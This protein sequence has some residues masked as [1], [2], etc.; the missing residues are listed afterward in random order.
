MTKNRIFGLIGLIWGGGMILGKILG[1]SPG[2]GGGAYGAGQ[3]AGL[4]FGGLLFVVGA[5]Y[6]FKKPT[7]K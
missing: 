7:P 6:F 5:Y 4:V 1:C 2:P 3:A